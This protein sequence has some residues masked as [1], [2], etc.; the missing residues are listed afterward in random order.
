MFNIILPIFSILLYTY[1]DNLIVKSIPNME[2]RIR[3]ISIFHCGITVFF[4]I[5]YLINL[6][7]SNIFVY[8]IYIISPGYF[9]LDFR[10]LLK[11]SDGKNNL[12]QYSYYLHHSASLI[13]IYYGNLYPTYLARSFLTEIS[14]PFLNISWFIR[15]AINIS[16]KNPYSNIYVNSIYRVNLFI[17]FTLFIIFRIYNLTELTY[18]SGNIYFCHRIIILFFTLLNYVWLYSIIKILINECFCEKKKYLK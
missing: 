14:T 8:I 6:F 11:K 17:Y 13:G 12:L 3:V 18:T 9:I 15:K 5:F 10:Y 4:S 7:S 16:K 1:L 2:Y